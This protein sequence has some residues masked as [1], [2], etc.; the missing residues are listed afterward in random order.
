MARRAPSND[1]A[2]HPASTSLA[3]MRQLW[4]L[5]HA[6]DVRSKWMARHLGVTGPQRLVVR[7]IGQRP[8]VS[9]GELARL[10]DLHP[11]TLTGILARLRARRLIVAVRDPEDRR[12]VRLSLTAAGRA[13]DRHRRGTVEA[14][15]QAALATVPARDR[16]AAERVLAAVRAQLAR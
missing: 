7:M 10:L 15:V 6:L 4:T 1:P 9:A 11:S 5:A 3:F 12:R 2:W 13:I 16:M 8:S 14:A